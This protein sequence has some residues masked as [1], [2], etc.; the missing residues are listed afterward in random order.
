MIDYA[1]RSSE[2]LR[3]RTNHTKKSYH[4]R[5]SVF[6]GECNHQKYIPE[7]PFRGKFYS[8]YIYT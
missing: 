4:S 5:K 2:D 6:S 8:K 7:Q 1:F 3:T